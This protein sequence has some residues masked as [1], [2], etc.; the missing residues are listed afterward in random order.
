MSHWGRMAQP[1]LDVLIT[2]GTQHRGGRTLVDPPEYGDD[3]DSD[4]ELVE[5]T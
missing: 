2:Q 4:L 1:R 5:R 3:K